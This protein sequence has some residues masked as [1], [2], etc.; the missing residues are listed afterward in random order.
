MTRTVSRGASPRL[1]WV[2]SLLLAACEAEPEPLEANHSATEQTIESQD[3]ELSSPGAQ[4]GKRLFEQPFPGSNGRACATCHVSGEGFTL[5]PESV[6]ARLRQIPQDPLFARIDADDPDAEQLSF[7]A[8]K[9]GLVRV[10]LKLPDNMDL[11]D[12]EGNVITPADRT[13][14]V[15]RGVP[16]VADVALS[17]P[18]QLDGRE[19]T[20][21]QQARNA[22]LSHSQGR[23]A[24]SFE[25]DRLA[26]FQRSTFSSPRARF[27]AGLMQVGLREEQIPT[28]EDYLPLSEQERR[29]R[30]VYDVACKA[31]H[32]GAS[33]ERIIDRD[34]HTFFSMA[35][36]EQGNVLFATAPGKPPTPVRVARPGVDFMNVG[37]GA[38]TYAG[39]I[40]LAPSFNASV[41]LPRYRFRFYSDAARTQRL[42]D[43]PPRPVT[44]S[45][46]PFDPRAVRDENG[47]PIVGPN[48]LPQQFTTDPGRAAVTGDPADFEAFDMPSL[49]GIASSAPYFHDNSRAT[50][51]DVV[52]EYSRF[53]LRLVTPMGLPTLPPEQPG[54][55]SESL[56][57]DQKNDLLAFLQRL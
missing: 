19:A 30:E 29:G 42:L 12:L 2:S 28:P 35:L 17:A 34:V 54:G 52:D 48:L 44:I 5:R 45:G 23:E 16:S 47:A 13:F 37:F 3:L 15:W 26:Q 10:V 43:L 20:L 7:E 24:S 21:Q 36:T 55:R 8:L 4:L 9:K 27:V 14:F 25:L 11:I 31:C 46:D 6:E 33:T 50:L 41:S 22:I 38:A 39:Q 1:A 57:P 40:G 18:Y 51:R 53:V 56:T 32:G 49:R